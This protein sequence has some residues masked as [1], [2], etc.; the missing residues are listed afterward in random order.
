MMHLMLETVSPVSSFE[1]HLK[2]DIDDLSESSYEAGVFLALQSSGIDPQDDNVS[3]PAKG[4]LQMARHMGRAPNLNNAYLAIKLSEITPC[5]AQLEWY[6]ARCD[7]S[8]DQ[9]GYY[10]TFEKFAAS[11]RESTINMNLFR[12]GTFWDRVIGMAARNELSHDFH[13]MPKWV[14]ASHS[15]MLLAEPLEIARYYRHGMHAKKGHYIKHGRNRRFQILERWWNRKVAVAAQEPQQNNNKR[16]RSRYASFTQDYLFWARVE[17]AKDW[18]KNTEEE[19]DLN[20]LG[21][22]LENMNR[23]ETYAKELIKNKEV[24]ID[25]LAKNSSYTLW[26]EKWKDLKAKLLRPPSTPLLNGMGCDYEEMKR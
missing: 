12:L 14:N 6:K 2:I 8:V 1:D 4:C 20:K 5:R 15:Y 7:E 22:F 19:E 3:K 21:S 25:V 18:L 11:R 16:N 9:C 17:E 24:S 23:F 26:A 13:C 10:D